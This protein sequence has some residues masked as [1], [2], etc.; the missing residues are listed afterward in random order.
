MVKA[1]LFDFDGTLADSAPAIVRTMCETFQ[2][3]G[4]PLPSESDIRATI[5]LPLISC[6]QRLGNLS[7]EKAREA[8]DTYRRLFPTFVQSHLHIFPQVRETLVALKEK[9]IRMAIVTSRERTSLERIMED[10]GI[11]SFF[12][13]CVTEAEGYRSKPAPDMAQALL[14]R[15]GLTPD[16]AL[17]VG[18]TTYDIDMGNSSGCRTVAV[19]YGNHDAPTLQSSSPTFLIDHFGDLLS[20]I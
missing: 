19:T 14:D 9:G 5:G 11:G 20:V 3:L 2:V 7:D 8:A 15:M 1:I 4:V 17:V 6:L 10:Q 18:D 16:E 12:E 13:T